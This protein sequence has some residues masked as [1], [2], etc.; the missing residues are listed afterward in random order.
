[1]HSEYS[2][3]KSEP[4]GHWG[5]CK[6]VMYQYALIAVQLNVFNPLC[7]TTW[8]LYHQCISFLHTLLDSFAY[9]SVAFNLLSE[10]SWAGDACCPFNVHVWTNK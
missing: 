9:I 6:T 1:M 7:T 5:N 8:C 4:S 10:C 2:I 3:I